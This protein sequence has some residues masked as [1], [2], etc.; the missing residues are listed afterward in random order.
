[1][2]ESRG[3]RRGA[4]RLAGVRRHGFQLRDVMTLPD[5]GSRMWLM[6]RDPA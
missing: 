5:G 6:W 1:M 4:W 3:E 2:A